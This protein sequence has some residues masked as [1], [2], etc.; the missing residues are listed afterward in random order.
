METHWRKKISVNSYWEDSLRYYEWY[1]LKSEWL[2]FFLVVEKN[3]SIKKISIILVI[4]YKKLYKNIILTF[5][6]K[7]SVSF[8]RLLHFF[9]SCLLYFFLFLFIVCFIFSPI[10]CFC[11]PSTVICLIFND[12]FVSILQYTSQV[13][14]SFIHFIFLSKQLHLS[15]VSC[16]LVRD[17]GN[18]ERLK[19]YM[20]TEWILV[21][22]KMHFWHLI[23]KNEEND[24]N[25]LKSGS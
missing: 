25:L 20:V 11:F 22:L 15:T 5:T 19:K 21:K 8:S 4:M 2:I 16:L 6:I 1:R 10:S 23:K 13:K 17:F 14:V 3:T 9:S 12:F 24:W 18:R 7:V